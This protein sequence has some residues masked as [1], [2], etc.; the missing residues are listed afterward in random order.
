MS[1]SSAELQRV[2]SA[3]AAASPDLR[4]K[5]KGEAEATL[6]HVNKLM[7]QRLLSREENK[8]AEVAVEILVRI[9]AIATG[10]GWW[11]RSK[12][13]LQL[14]QMYLGG[15]APKP[16]SAL[17]RGAVNDDAVKLKTL[18]DLVV[19]KYLPMSGEQLKAALTRDFPR[20]NYDIGLNDVTFVFP[21]LPEF[22]F[23][24]DAVEAGA[25]SLSVVAREGTRAS[26]SSSPMNGFGIA[27]YAMASR[28]PLRAGR[29]R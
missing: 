27:L 5:M 19:A 17:I 6:A 23:M 18:A 25:N 11:F 3:V 14:T 29:K 9:E 21:D 4:L 28:I 15:A 16:F 22:S 1:L 7:A 10:R 24:V 26:C 20:D 8:A 12:R 2:E 13:R